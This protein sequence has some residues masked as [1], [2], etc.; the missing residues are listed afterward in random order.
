ML[1]PLILLNPD[2]DWLTSLQVF[3]LLFANVNAATVVAVG[4]GNVG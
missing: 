2:F 1:S 4:D 3:G